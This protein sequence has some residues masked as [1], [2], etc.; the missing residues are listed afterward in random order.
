M[1]LTIRVFGGRW[2]R[3][4]F[5]LHS[6]LE[7]CGSAFPPAPPRATSFPPAHDC[8]DVGHRDPDRRASP[9]LPTGTQPRR[10][11][12]IVD[13]GWR[14]VQTASNDGYADVR[15]SLRP[16]STAKSSGRR[17]VPTEFRITARRGDVG[18]SG[19]AT[20]FE[21]ASTKLRAPAAIASRAATSAVLRR[22]LR[23]ARRLP[24]PRERVPTERFRR[25]SRTLAGAFEAYCNIARSVL[26]NGGID[27]T[28]AL[29][30]PYLRAFN[31]VSE[32]VAMVIQRAFD[33]VVRVKF[34]T[35]RDSS[36]SRF[37]FRRT[38]GLRRTCR[39]RPSESS[40]LRPT[41]AIC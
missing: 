3:R 17:N 12:A 20:L 13:S 35:S 26:N 18:E 7:G 22:T 25:T 9:K 39:T 19:Q 2:R 33:L 6:P 16:I 15:R 28:P 36:R 37:R 30:E 41:A 8:A 11:V 32:T 14:A 29:R 1:P 5:V 40:R 24:S 38:S 21:S 31:K 34:A 10:I 4:F 27:L 23:C